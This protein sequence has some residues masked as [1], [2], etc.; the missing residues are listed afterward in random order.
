MRIP[1]RRDRRRGAVLPLVAVS[2]IALMGMLAMAIDLGMITLA[3]NQAQ[4]A[5]DLAA[6]TGARQL[7]GLNT[8]GNLNNYDAAEPQARIAAQ[9]NRVLG[10]NIVDGDITVDI[11]YYAYDSVTQ[12]F[13][14]VFGQAKPAEESWSAVEVEIRAFRPTF[15]AKVLGVSSYNA[16]ASARAVHRPRDIAIVLDFSGSMR[17]STLSAYPK[18][19]DLTG[20]LNP[21]PRY[22]QFGH[23]ST[24]T[25][26]GKMHFSSPFY[27]ESNGETLAQ[28]NLT[29][30]TE[31]GPP[32]VHDFLMKDAGGA[33]VMGFHRTHDPYDPNDPFPPGVYDP[34][35]AAVPAPENFN[36]QSPKF[37]PN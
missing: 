18:N 15:F 28:T 34:M 5:A 32:I 31:N 4:N 14:A 25:M 36:D 30:P 29:Y 33:L 22:P 24:S 16:I 20:S 9:Q 27:V 10:D 21:D 2:M 8:T 6:L 7:N 1:S 26:Q 23:W 11:G 3:R 17:F 19:G 13:T 12:S 35:V 37:F